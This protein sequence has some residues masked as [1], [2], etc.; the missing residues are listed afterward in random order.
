MQPFRLQL[1]VY[2][3]TAVAPLALAVNGADLY[4]ESLVA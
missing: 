3:G 2:T 1:G 4:Q